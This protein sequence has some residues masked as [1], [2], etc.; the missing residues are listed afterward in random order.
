MKKIGIITIHNSPNYGACLQ[1]FALYKYISSKEGIDCEIIDL[2]RPHYKD[3]I[4][5]KIYVPYRSSTNTLR[6]RI[7]CFIKSFMKWRKNPPLYSQDAIE[8]FNRFNGLI[9]LS[10]PYRGI[11]EL[12]A[13]PPQYDLY[14]TGSDQLWNPSQNYCL[15][16]YFLTFAPKGA[17]K[18]SYA[19][20]IGITNLMENEKRDFKKWLGSYNDISVREEQAKLLLETFVDNKYITQVDDPTFLLTVD[21]WKRIAIYPQQQSP[22]ILLFTLSF[23]PELLT[24]TLKLGKESGLEITNLAQ[25]Q[26]KST[27]NEYKSVV[28]AGPREFLG[29]IANAELVI[30]D[31]FHC[32]VFSI[33]MGTK[34][35]YTYISPCNNRGSRI[36]DLLHT[37]TLDHHLLSID[38][39]ESY[40]QL[41]QNRLEYAQIKQI[42]NNKRISGQSFLDKHLT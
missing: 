31:S 38:L 23:S 27:N 8:K 17:K 4:P 2:H 13:N 16:P 32:T 14:V 11:D 42:I 1:S 7:K 35:F 37:F 10:K 29:Y 30:T 5:S 40:S 18:I 9:K 20:S 12:Y 6:N 28:D 19:A 39:Q 34:N 33:L 15:E 25:I 3:F 21:E 24:Y 36:K 41:L 26:P 22:Y